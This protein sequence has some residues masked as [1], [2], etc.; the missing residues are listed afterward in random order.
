MRQQ[1]GETPRAA[2]AA[3][4]TLQIVHDETT[5]ALCSRCGVPTGM[6]PRWWFDGEDH[7]VPFCEECAEHAD[8][9]P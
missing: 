3:V 6:H 8:E 5:D 4:P 1:D 2:A 9:T 7:L